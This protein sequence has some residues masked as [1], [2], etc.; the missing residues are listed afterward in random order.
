MGESHRI[1]QCIHH[2][3]AGRICD[4]DG[5]LITV[6]WFKSLIR[7]LHRPN[8]LEI[9]AMLIAITVWFMLLLLSH[10]LFLARSL[11]LF[12]SIFQLQLFF[13]FL[14]IDGLETPFIFNST[15]AA[16]KYGRAFF[17][18]VI[19]YVIEYTHFSNWIHI[20]AVRGNRRVNTSHTVIHSE[21][22]CTIICIQF[23]WNEPS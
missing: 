4:D 17:S 3:N 8:I 23:A 7:V 16:K 22:V 11:F 12:L 19:L 18:A 10:S 20:A 6:V 14:Y 15:W 5:S 9:Y 21:T 2:M 1:R 13:G